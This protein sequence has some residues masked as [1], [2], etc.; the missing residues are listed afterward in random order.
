M[1]KQST[2][3]TMLYRLGLLVG[4]RSKAI[5][6]VAIIVTM[7]S[8][9]VGGG[10]LERFSLARFQ[11]AGSESL[12]AAALLQDNFE[13]GVPNI[14]IVVT[15]R[16]GNPDSPAV[17]AAAKALA[18]KLAA[19]PSV[20][21]IASYWDNHSPVL[22]GRDGGHAL[23][24]ARVTGSATEARK[25]IGALAPKFTQTNKAIQTQ[26]GGRDEVFRQVG[27]QARKDFARA[28]A[29]IL[30]VMIVLLYLVY[31]RLSAALLT[32][33]V[34]VF[35]VFGTLA[36]LALLLPFTEISTFAS[37]LTLVMGMGLGLDYSLLVISR[38]REQRRA[39]Q[40]TREAIATTVATAG[41]TV[42]FSGTTV[43][44]SLLALLLFPFPFLQSFAYAGLG[45]VLTAIVGAV[46]LLPAALTLLGDRT[47]RHNSPH[48][49]PGFWQ[50]SALK[51]MQRPV[52]YGVMAL[53]VIAALA[54]PIGS[55]RFGLPDDRILPVTASSRQAQQHIRDHFTAEQADA[56]QVIATPVQNAPAHTQQIT[57]Y[58]QAL[59]EV[60]GVAQ[61]DFAGGTFAKGTHVA[62]IQS[63][64]QQFIHAT[65]AWFS[66]VPQS[67]RLEQDAAGLV[68]D[69]RHVPA[70]FPTY[71][72][73]STAEVTDF[74]RSL[75]ARMPVVFA[76]ILGA[77]FILM[78]IMT[79][80]LLLPIIA[81]VLNTLSLAV[82]FGIIVRIF[83]QGNLA[84]LLDFTATGFIEPT[85]PILMVC[86]AYG[87]SM[88]YQLFMLSRIKEAYDSTHNHRQAVLTGLQRSAPIILPA[89]AILACTFAI[90][91]SSS[92]TQLKMLAVGM[93]ATV[94]VDATIIRLV[95][96]PALMELAGPATWWL[97]HP[98]AKLYAK[99]R[100]DD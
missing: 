27:A 9:I 92:I 64:S 37:N 61:V 45:V 16:D 20:I 60:P 82:M 15:A 29:I 55:L 14:T 77:T 19:E 10:A 65:S 99:I 50:Q 97:P 85:I 41:R 90:Y 76:V 51:I 3:S 74:R 71:V 53:A 49:G 58:A 91:L 30:P 73:G 8:A 44:I 83:Q 80:S 87:L 25:T 5:M 6:A 68:A 66:V 56:L 36:L 62:H 75:L 23:I 54:A 21:N 89:A 13:V 33:G 40:P 78:S 2:K 69:V 47:L 32:L 67:D 93:A 63:Q 39:G 72:G 94:C 52:V 22:R 38:F 7:A 98:L 34:G 43:A 86:V 46:I 88:D 100:F 28:E 70:P 31:R 1:P 96:L 59:S 18:A 95:L 17:T 81:S 57:A 24:I 26:V 4:Q 35:A 84:G 12:Q 42:I 48:A 79:G 11:A